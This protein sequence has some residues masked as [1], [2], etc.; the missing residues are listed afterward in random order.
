MENNHPGEIKQTK[1]GKIKPVEITKEMEK[2]YLDYAMSVIV[3]RALPDIR[4][5]LKP[6]HRRILFAMYKMGLIHSSKYTKSAK[7][8]GEVM[9]KY[10]PHGDQPIYDALVRMAQ[11]FSLRYPLVDGQGN[12]GSVDGDPAAAMRY[13]ISSQSRVITNSGLEKIKELKKKNPHI[14]VIS[15]DNQVNNISKWFDS[16]KH[17]T[18]TIET[19]RGFSLCGSLNHP[20]LTWNKNKEGKPD[21][22]WKLFQNI[23]PG[24]FAVINRNPS[25]F[26]KD[27]LLQKFY[28]KIKNTRIKKHQL[29]KKMNQS[30]AFILGSLVADGNIGKKQVG[31]CN[32]HQDYLEK[33]KSAFKKIFPDCRHTSL[34]IH[35]LHIIYFLKNLGLK[36]AVAKTKIVPEIIFLSSKKSMASFIRGYAEGDG[37]AYLSG[38]PEIAFTSKSRLL[39]T[40]LQLLL[41]RFGIESSFRLQKRNIYKL[42]IRGYQ[43]LNLFKE[44]INFITRKKQT[45]LFQLCQ[46]NKNG[47]IMSKTD[48][49]PYLAE[50]LRDR[51][52][53][54][55][56]L[57]WLKK[58]NLDRYA[59][60]KKYWPKL[61]KILTTEDKV[62]LETLIKRKYLFD[63]IVKVSPSGRKNVY[64]LKVESPCHSFISNGFISHNTEARPAKI[65]QEILADIDKETVNFIDNFDASLQEPTFLPAKLPNLLLAGCEGIAV[66]MATKIPPHNLKE[67]VNALI[68]LID[69][70][71]EV[72]IGEF[73]S[74]I[75]LDDLLQHIQGPDFPT[76]GQI[77]DARGIAEA[78]ATG[79][80]RI[81]IRAKARIEEGK[82]GKFSI[83][84][85]E[86]P[87]QVNK[88]TLIVH[89]ADLVKKKKISGISAIRDESDQRGMQIVIELKRIAKPKTV[90]NRLFKFTAMQ[91][92]Y[93]VN[94]VAL[95]DNVP[96]TITLKTALREFIR[97]R[98]LIVSRRT[99]F[100]LQ[101]AKHRIHILEGLMIAL[102]HLD[103]VITTIK[104]AQNADVARERL[105]KKFSL[106]EIQANAIL[107]MRLR[108]LAR[109]ERE[110]IENEYQELN[111]LI[112]YLISLLTDPKKI[113][114]VI[115]KECQELIEKY[116]DE[117]RTK[118][119]KKPL[120]QFSEEAL[121]PAEACMVTLTKGGYVKRLRPDTYR[122][123]R[124]GGKGVI[125]MKTK[126]MDEVGFLLSANTHDSILFFTNKGRVFQL[127]VY[128][129]PEAERTAK[130]QAVINLIDIE[131]DEKIQAMIA[132]RLDNVAMKYLF[133]ATKKGMVKKTKIENYQNIRS[134]GLIAI[135]L[136]RGDELCWV[137]PTRGQEHVLLV[138]HFGKSIRF[139]E[140]DV[141][142]T[143]RDT[144]G[145]K[146]IRL[147]KNDYVVVMET[148]TSESAKPQ[149]KRRKFFRHLVTVMEKGYGKRTPI[150]EH[151]LQKRGGQGVKVANLTSKNGKVIA[152]RLVDQKVNSLALTSKKGQMIKLPLR[153]IPAMG[154]D[155]QG[156]IMM[157]FSQKADSVAALACLEK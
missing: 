25:L 72:K 6:V 34:E 35:S 153:N 141:R 67:V 150:S 1:A 21:L 18:K 137:K 155:T 32:S 106:T 146:G 45:K 97:H 139:R 143:G 7:I 20:I 133:M 37:S 84:V 73:D 60:L 135:K 100:E 12:F 4:D 38:A 81:P 41:L 28:P 131:Q 94:M 17:P 145:V 58:H 90:L 136:A 42:F 154:R 49:I 116:G 59:K 47:R 50:Y 62:L 126:E 117:R 91:I 157:R 95:I 48:Y 46:R 96:Q 16:G 82:G 87:Y 13:C 80:G 156:V 122:S 10:H 2:S 14:K 114:A 64:S 115:K 93:P 63:K 83:I 132:L 89:I 138:T 9:G 128:E 78:Y 108:Q 104:R 69:K 86:L 75:T 120:G 92:V 118:V 55:G 61:K 103:A 129:L 30:L 119:F 99:E 65:S 85:E 36:P 130:G 127:K 144:I 101:Q 76:G 26:P 140:E 151:P 43:N 107:E 39:M 27:P 68:T 66:G 152:S 15:L 148:F 110:K 88:A 147:Q 142:P 19:F 124:R 33:F 109:L 11:S 31:F 52:D 79:K 134:S 23:A 51:R 56:N 98:Q 71:S 3:Q 105:M 57:E 112:E 77:Y 40:Q 111:K 44:E 125:G 123:Q 121:M 74:Q 113:L 102:Q 8:T 149:D 53:Y 29:P 24:D 70:T 54:W 22:Q 5:G